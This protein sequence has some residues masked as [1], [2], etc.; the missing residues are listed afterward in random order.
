MQLRRPE[1]YLALGRRNLKGTNAGR[2]IP[3]A[4]D[5]ARDLINPL[6]AAP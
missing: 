6:Q 4:I 5:A 1:T 2:R 3:R